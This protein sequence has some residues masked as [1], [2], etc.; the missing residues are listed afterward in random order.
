MR[1]GVPPQDLESH[2]HYATEIAEIFDA[3]A[4]RIENVRLK[5]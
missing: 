3:L 4:V 5:L 2:S 1:R